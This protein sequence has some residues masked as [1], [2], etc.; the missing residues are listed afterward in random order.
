MANLI[1]TTANIRM[2][3]VDQMKPMHCQ[4]LCQILPLQPSVWIALQ[5]P[6]LMW[7]QMAQS[8]TRYSSE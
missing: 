2:T 6:W 7:N 1:T 3:I 4:R 5:K 8:H